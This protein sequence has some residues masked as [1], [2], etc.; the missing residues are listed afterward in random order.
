M[1][2]M[3]IKV[4]NFDKFKGTVAV[5]DVMSQPDIVTAVAAMRSYR[6]AVSALA[7]DQNSLS[8]WIQRFA[9]HNDR[10]RDFP[11]DAAIGVLNHEGHP[12]YTSSVINSDQTAWANLMA[13]AEQILASEA[14]WM[15]VKASQETSTVFNR[16]FSSDISW[17]LSWAQSNAW[18]TNIGIE[19]LVNQLI[20]AVRQCEGQSGAGSLTHNLHEP[21]W[22]E[23][24]PR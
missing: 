8:G 18:P 3:V 15:V 22:D 6:Q 4:A 7:N 13:S 11:M 14:S 10:V 12:L 17:L 9:N 23:D 19:Y 2:V 24:G 1:T 20:N 21:P 5:H 16:L